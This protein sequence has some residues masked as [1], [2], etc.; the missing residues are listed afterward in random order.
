[1]PNLTP[2][3][4]PAFIKGYLS[5]VEADTVAEAIEKYSGSISDFFKC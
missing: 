2:G 5:F 1:M 3:T 4:Y